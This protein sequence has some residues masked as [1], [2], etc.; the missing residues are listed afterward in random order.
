MARESGSKAIIPNAASEVTILTEVI[1]E[2]SEVDETIS[3][4]NMIMEIQEARGNNGLWYGLI[5]EKIWVMK[6][7][8]E[9]MIPPENASK[10]GSSSIVIHLTP[11]SPNKN[12]LD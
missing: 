3:A 12:C 9:I 7:N 8:D 11:D 2:S 6:N 1:T 4:T 5:E 10:M